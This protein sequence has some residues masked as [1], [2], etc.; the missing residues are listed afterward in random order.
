TGSVIIIDA[1]HLFAKILNDCPVGIRCQFV[2]LIQWYQQPVPWFF[3]CVIVCRVQCKAV[4]ETAGYFTEHIYVR[5]HIVD[6]NRKD[7]T[8]HCI[9]IVAPFLY[10]ATNKA[11]VTLL[12]SDM[13]SIQKCKELAEFHF[14]I[15]CWSPGVFIF[16][17][18]EI[19]FYII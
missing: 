17:Y 6:I 13:W 1:Q 18:R 2:T 9:I 12:N 16:E 15:F 10:S 8:I 7:G 14:S 11:A 4:I 19:D 5:R 3:W